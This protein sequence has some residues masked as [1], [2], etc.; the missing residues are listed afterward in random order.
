MAIKAGAN[1]IATVAVN[2]ASDN[3]AQIGRYQF[4]PST[5][6]GAIWR[7]DTTTGIVRPDNPG[8]PFESKQYKFD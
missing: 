7:I 5:P 3:R 6:P 4:H 2:A 1:A 8:A